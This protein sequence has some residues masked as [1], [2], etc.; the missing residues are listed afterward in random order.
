MPEPTAA[1]ALHE[2]LATRGVHTLLAQFTDLLGVA[3]GKYVPLAQLDTLLRTGAGF[4]GTSIA[5][6]GLP[7][8]GPRSEYYGRG[9]PATA[10]ENRSR[11]SS[12]SI[13]AR[14]ITG[15]PRRTAS[16]ISGFVRFTADE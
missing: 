15:I 13:S 6:T 11:I 14:G 3:R 9:D 1:H 8:S 16:A 2:H 10:I 5:G 12:A 4:S 7:R